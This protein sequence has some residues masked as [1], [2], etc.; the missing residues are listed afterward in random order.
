MVGVAGDAEALGPSFSADGS[1]VAAAWGG[2]N[3]SGMVRVLDLSTGRVV[4]EIPVSNPIDTAISPDGRQVAVATL[5]RV[6]EAG[7]VFDVDTHEEALPLVGPDCCL[8]PNGGGV[9]WSPDGRFIAGT[10]GATARVWDA[11]TGTLQHTLP[12]HSGSVLG[13]AWSP[14]SS[15][16]V[17]GGS[18]GTA[19]VWEIGDESLEER[20]TL[21]AQE[22]QSG[23]LGVAFSPDGTRVMAGDAGITAVKVWDLG[24]AGDAEWANLPAPGYPAAE[25]MPDGQR[26]VTP[27]WEAG[28]EPGDTGPDALTIWDPKTGREIRTIGPPADYF[29]FQAFDL[30]P[31]GSRVAL[32]GQSNPIDHGGQ[33]AVRAWDASTGEELW[34]IAHNLDVNEVAFSPDGEYVATADWGGVAKIVDRSGRVLRDLTGTDFNFSDVAFSSDGRLVATAEWQGSADRV[35][36]WDWRRGEVL[37]RIPAE[38]PYAQVD[39]D[40]SGPRVVVSGADGLAEV[41]DAESGR[42]LAVMVGPP[43]GVNDLVFSPDGSRV[44]TAS[45][46]GLVRLFDADTGALQLSLRGSGCEVKGVAF[47]PDGTKLASTSWCDGVRIWALDIDDLLEIARHEAG[48]T[49]ADA[50]CRQYL[51]VDRCPLA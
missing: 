26:V 12:G 30:S 33:S 48:R 37:F 50:E 9:S 32:G 47:S 25:F 41:W 17:T 20:W 44:A 10:S 28:V 27:S 40:P 18:D 1:L 29:W 34:H 3:G 23:I 36:V 39:F 16:L 35:S 15:R 38:G 2:E 51:H 49:I 6:D 21:S 42:R 45:V 43:G 11:E 5:Y 13:V 14:D 4:S 46:D 22:S 31:D 7:A 8:Y 19:R 24:P